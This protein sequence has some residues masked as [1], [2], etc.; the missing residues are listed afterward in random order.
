[1]Q[2]I[3][4]SLSSKNE[5]NIFNFKK[6]FSFDKRCAESKRIRIEFPDRRPVICQRSS[7]NI[8]ELDKKKYLVPED[9]TMGQF[10][11]VIRRRMKL[12]PEM[13]LYT[14]IGGK[15]C[16]PNN[17][18]LLGSIYSDYSDDD[19]FLYIDYSGENTFG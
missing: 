3:F 5:S 16:I 15:G 9:L 12:P 2:K 19:G 1:M 18:S 10:M 8:P 17:T 11:Y 6:K 14:F 13:G 7:N 4:N